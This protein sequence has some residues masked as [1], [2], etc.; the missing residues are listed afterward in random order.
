VT[1]LTEPGDSCT[2]FAPPQEIK[3]KKIILKLFF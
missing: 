2:N 3:N 1:K